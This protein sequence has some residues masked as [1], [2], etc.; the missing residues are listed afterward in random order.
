MFG[1]LKTLYNRT[2]DAVKNGIKF[3][4]PKVIGLVTG[5]SKILKNMP[6]TIGAVAGAIDKGLSVAKSVVN[7]LPDGAAKDKLNNVID[8]GGT[9]AHA[10]ADKA[11]SFI[12]KAATVVNRMQ[13]VVGS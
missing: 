7:S 11:T 12:G 5:A 10:G 4:A 3:A 6:G 13:T 1:G 2:K 9:A 8:K